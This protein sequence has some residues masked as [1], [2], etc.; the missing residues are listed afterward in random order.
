MRATRVQSP[1]GAE[2]L[3]YAEVS[4]PKPGPGKALVRIE[5][6]RV[7]S[8]DV[9]HRRGLYPCRCRSRRARKRPTPSKRSAPRYRR[10]ATAIERLLIP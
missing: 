2:V 6:V 8:I 5:A 3:E 4:F 1:G 9:Y 10:R 7:N